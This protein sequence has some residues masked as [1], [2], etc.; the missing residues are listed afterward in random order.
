MAWTPTRTA[1]PTAQQ[2]GA[3]AIEF[4]LVFPLFLLLFFG[5]VFFGVTFTLQ[6]ALTH[7]AQVGARAGLSVDPGQSSNFQQDLK[8]E[9]IAEINRIK[10]LPAGI[11]QPPEVKFEPPPEDDVHWVTVTI[12]LPKEQHPLSMLAT[13]VRTLSLSSIDVSTDLTGQATLRL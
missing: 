7:A 12:T 3:A 8:D 6:H 10:W 2:R 11:K 5:M 9:I 4:A 1:A 13:V